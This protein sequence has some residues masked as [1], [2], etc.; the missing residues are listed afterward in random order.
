MTTKTALSSAALAGPKVGRVRKGVPYLLRA[1][2]LEV[3]D[4][5]LMTGQ[6]GR[7]FIPSI[8]GLGHSPSPLAQTYPRK[9]LS[10]SVQRWRFLIA[11]AR[12]KFRLSDRKR[13]LLKIPNRERIAI[14]HLAPE[15]RLFLVNGHSSLVTLLIHGGAIKT[16]RKP[17]YY[18][19]LKISNRQ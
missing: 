18:S 3:T 1:S 7:G 15:P 6:E 5:Q 2:G 9:P 4:L 13:S 14:F 8:N 10:P 11:N 12:L 17:F 16:P 19:N